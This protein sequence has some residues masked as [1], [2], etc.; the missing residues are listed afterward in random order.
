VPVD[1]LTACSI[2]VEHSRDRKITDGS[3]EVVADVAIDLGD[4][5][6]D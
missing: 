5:A 1:F 6:T 2:T 3:I 4:M